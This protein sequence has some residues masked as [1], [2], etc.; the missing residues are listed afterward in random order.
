MAKKNSDNAQKSNNYIGAFFSSIIGVIAG[1]YAV[2]YIISH[3]YNSVGPIG[4][5]CG[6]FSLIFIRRRSNL[7]GFWCLILA[8]MASLYAELYFFHRHLTI[9][10]FLENV[11]NLPPKTL[12]SIAFGTFVAFYFGR[13]R[14]KKIKDSGDE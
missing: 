3:G 10:A 2:K 13:G 7:F 11:P 8:L 5:F 9:N 1:V 4:F 6:I 12:A 14:D